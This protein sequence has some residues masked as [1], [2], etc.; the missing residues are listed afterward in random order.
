[1]R[2]TNIFIILILIVG[3]SSFVFLYSNVEI[4]TQNNIYVQD[5]NVE[6][7]TIIESEGAFNF[8]T[9]YDISEDYRLK[10]IENGKI[11]TEYEDNE[12]LVFSP[13]K[14]HKLRM[15]K[16]VNNIEYNKYIKKFSV[17][18]FNGGDT[19]TEVYTNSE[20]LN[21]EIY[22]DAAI[23]SSSENYIEYKD[24]TGTLY[25]SL[26][27]SNNIEYYDNFKLYSEVDYR[28]KD[29]DNYYDTV[30]DIYGVKTSYNPA[31]ILLED[32]EFESMYNNDNLA[33]MYDGSVIYINK[34]K[35]GSPQS[36]SIALE[37]V[38]IHEIAH[39]TTEKVFD[40]PPIWFSEGLSEYMETLYRYENNVNNGVFNSGDLTC[41]I[42]CSTDLSEVSMKD[43]NRYYN[44]N[45]SATEMWDSE[46]Y[47]STFKY[48]MSEIII[49]NYLIDNSLEEQV[50][51]YN[52]GEDI[53]S[54]INQKPCSDSDDIVNCIDKRIN[55]W[56]GHSRSG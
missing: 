8:I 7:D 15:E 50:I 53:Y 35:I 3:I 11:L 32:D 31:I 40:S 10:E 56:N 27:N 41:G 28:F 39:D 46:K 44:S 55:H 26:K 13:F 23:S 6:V 34:N 1:M 18:P 9:L 52:N 5:E 54:D 37:S 22:G 17:S 42:S 16:S 36:S 4:S 14:S 48:A 30:K 38:M 33:G 19:T 45:V 21:Y 43:L 29:I 12:F 20:I 24:Y 51:E 47:N 49:R 25:L 2:K